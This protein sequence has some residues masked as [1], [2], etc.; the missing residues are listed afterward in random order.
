[1]TQYCRTLHQIRP[2]LS[3]T[4][5]HALNGWLFNCHEFEFVPLTYTVTSSAYRFTAT[6]NRDSS[7]CP[8]PYIPLRITN[9]SDHTAL[10]ITAI[11]EWV[12]RRRSC[13][14]MNM[15]GLP[16]DIRTRDRI[17][18]LF[19]VGPIAKCNAS[20]EGSDRQGIFTA[21]AAAMG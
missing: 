11:S 10:N 4:Q 20:Q 19:A 13:R 16:P 18:A 9:G 12:W 17:Q 6:G 7:V 8:I 3:P 14:W 15:A 2:R 5:I 21:R 1:M